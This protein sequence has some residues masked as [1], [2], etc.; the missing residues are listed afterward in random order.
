MGVAVVQLIIDAMDA[1]FTFLILAGVTTAYSPL[2]VV[3]WSWG[4]EWRMERAG[5]LVRKAEKKDR[6]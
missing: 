3:E 4:P 5:R 1:D 2:V 6:V